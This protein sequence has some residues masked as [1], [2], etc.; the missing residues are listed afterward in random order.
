VPFDIKQQASFTFMT[1]ENGV[2]VSISP[3]IYYVLGYPPAEL[4]GKSFVT[5]AARD[6][7]ERSA[8]LLYQML[9]GRQPFQGA[10]IG[11]ACKDGQSLEAEISGRPVVERG[12]FH[13]YQGVV[14][15]ISQYVPPEA[16]R[17]SDE[18]E[19]ELLMDLVCH[20]IHNM[21]QAQIGYLELAMRSMDQDSPA[22]S[23]IEKCLAMVTSSSGLLRNVQKL[24]Q[25]ST[26]VRTLE[27]VDIGSV[28]A[29]AVGQSASDNRRDLKI[30]FT[31]EGEYKVMANALLKDA[32]LNILGNAIKHTTGPLIIDVHLKK[33]REG[34]MDYCQV[35]FDDNGPGIPDEMKRRL[36][37]RYERGSTPASGKGLG[38]YLVRK[39]VEGYG[40]RVWGEDRV[41]GNHHQGSRFVIELPLA[42]RS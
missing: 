25:I 18:H 28:L 26:G 1:D 5:I 13:G 42:G 38:L 35:T 2:F 40:G 29:E 15:A 12:Q 6:S 11:L 39:L 34:E 24:Q 21:N 37:N 4:L 14:L 32:F 19:G 22:Y 3:A 30:N 10:A 23:Y 20:D 27:L 36:F 17:G 8:A 16:A 31:L 33:F 7:I 41:P 9:Q